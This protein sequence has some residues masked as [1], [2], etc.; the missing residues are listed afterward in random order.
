[1]NKEYTK[2]GV[3][4]KKDGVIKF[5]NVFIFNLANRPLY[6]V[7]KNIHSN[8]NTNIFYSY[9]IVIKRNDNINVYK[10]KLLEFAY[11]DYKKDCV[12]KLE[13]LKFEY[14]K[15]NED[16][17]NFKSNKLFKKF[18]RKDKIEYIVKKSQN[19]SIGS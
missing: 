6:D 2:L 9:V 18:S 8:I 19:E 15:I 7:H 10:D 1:M 17:L 3:F 16:L 11:N 4:F 14:N 13:N 12:E 5:E